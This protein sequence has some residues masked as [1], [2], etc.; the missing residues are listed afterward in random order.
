MG[1]G[2]SAGGLEA[3]ELFFKNT[4]ENTGM[5]FVVIQHLDPDHKGILPELL[6]RATGMKVEKISERM[7]ARPDHVYVIPPNRSLTIESGSFRLYP[8]AE[9]RGLRLPIDIF[10]R[11]LAND[12]EERSIGVILSGMGS[13][14]SSGLKAIKEK[15]GLVVVQDPRSAKFDAMPKN[16]MASV[17]SD[18]VASPEELPYR[19]IVYLKISP[20]IKIDTIRDTSIRNNIEKIIYLIRQHTGHDFSSYKKSG[21]YRRIE[22]RKGVHQISKIQDY[23]KFLH[24]NSKEVDILFNEL[25]VGVTNFFR[26]HAVWDK[27]RDEVLPEMLASFHDGASLRAWIPGCSTGEEAY[28]LAIVFKEA[29]EKLKKPKNLSL[30]IFATDIDHYAIEKA[31]R[32][33]YQRNITADVS[34]ERINK[35]F[36]L[37]A[38]GFRVNASLREMI[39][40][41]EQ[42]VV[43]DPPFTRLDMLS[44]RNLF[45][46]LEA[47]KQKKL[48]SLFYYSL[49]PGGVLVLGSAET[50]VNNREGFKEVDS[51]LKIYRRSE[52]SYAIHAEFIDFSN[53]THSAKSFEKAIKMPPKEPEN[54]QDLADQHVIQ[55]FSPPTVLVNEKGDIVYI[56]GRTGKYLEPTA[57]KANWNI[58]SMARPGLRHELPG[59]FRL[60]LQSYEPVILP[61]IKVGTNGGEQYVEV[62]IQRVKNPAAIRNM[63]IVVFR[64]IPSPSDVQKTVKPGKK[65]HKYNDLEKE[66]EKSYEDLQSTREEMQASQ[67]ELKSINEELQSTNEELQSTNEELTTSKEEMQSM[68]EELQTLNTEL[69]SKVNDL[70]M[71][72][73]DMKNLLNNTEIATLFLDKELSIR[74]FTDPV[75]KIF[76]LRTADLGRPFTDLVTNL[77]Y[78]DLESHAR[79]VLRT[80][81]TIENS[82]TTKNGLWFNVRIMPYRTED[83]RIDGLVLTFTDITVSTKLEIDL[84]KA[85]EE[86]DKL[87][88]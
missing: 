8:P 10:L 73:S 68:N 58:Y 30:Q 55:N 40:F 22:R 57:G 24:E 29:Q 21:I 38:E 79:Q 4:P 43:K 72:N 60:A 61:A 16:A 75:R 13:D 26:D 9:A 12:L 71:A 86:I 50:L 1:I 39:V 77:Q 28:S 41:A 2:A 47:E 51:R 78:P 42:S 52:M 56:T 54:I 20:P 81:V 63:I 3:L 87:K 19:I 45:I 84:Q 36:N 66:L 25:M 23:V 74:R 62:T 33:V 83:D 15:G 80:L 85:N 49:K 37:D 31:R 32:G 65:S 67:E 64:D 69:Q 53:A 48:I 35:F 17:I 5:A 44:C 11:S 76:K 6:Q 14:G 82:V 34:P 7:K 46:Y 18:I 59:A 88:K 27:L 70:V